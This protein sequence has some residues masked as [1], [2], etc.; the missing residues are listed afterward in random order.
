MYVLYSLYIMIIKDLKVRSF[1]LKLC[2]KQNPNCK[3]TVQQFTA[4]FLEHMN[5]TVYNEILTV[6]DISECPKLQK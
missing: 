1:N 3:S 2:L 6:S 4:H 5:R